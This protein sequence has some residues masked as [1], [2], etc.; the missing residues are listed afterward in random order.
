MIVA[1]I[2]VVLMG[3]LGA[4]SGNLK[5][6]FTNVVTRLDGANAAN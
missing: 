3:V 1:L 5:A 2:S 4:L 6:S